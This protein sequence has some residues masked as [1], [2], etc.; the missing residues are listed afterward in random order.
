MEE[1]WR[2]EVAECLRPTLGFF[3]RSGVQA[4]G[5]FGRERSEVLSIV[6]ERLPSAYLFTTDAD[7]SLESPNPPPRPHA[8][9]IPMLGPAPSPAPTAKAPPYRLEGLLI[10][11]S[12]EPHRDWLR[13]QFERLSPVA[14]EGQP[15]LPDVEMHYTAHTVKRLIELLQAEETR[16]WL[17]PASA[18]RAFGLGTEKA[19]AERFSGLL[20]EKSNLGSSDILDLE[21]RDFGQSWASLRPQILRIR[22]GRLEPMAD[23]VF[24]KKILAV[25]GLGFL[26][27]LGLLMLIRHDGRPVECDEPTVTLE[28]LPRW[29]DW[30]AQGVNWV[31]RQRRSRAPRPRRGPRPRSLP[32]WWGSPWRSARSICSSCS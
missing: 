4:V 6:R 20:H 13:L 30:W 24:A 28:W 21:N 11:T 22:D 15:F 5:V 26:A 10:V 18:R 17:S 14:P 27:G 3:D 25:G 31:D 9:E 32:G 8:G 16:A 29:D 7:W 19:T 23:T 2:S 1:H 12:P